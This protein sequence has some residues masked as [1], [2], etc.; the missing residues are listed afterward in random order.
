LLYCFLW[1]CFY[2]YLFG[3]WLYRWANVLSQEARSFF[4]RIS[5]GHAKNWYFEVGQAFD[6]LPNG[7]LVP[8]T[9]THIRTTCIQQMLSSRPWASSAEARIFLEGWDK[10][11]MWAS[12]K[13]SLDSCSLQSDT[14][15][16]CCDYNPFL[17]EDSPVES[18]SLK[19]WQRYLFLFQVLAERNIGHVIHWPALQISFRSGLSESLVYKTFACRGLMY[20]LV[21]RARPASLRC[22][23]VEHNIRILVG[24]LNKPRA[25][26]KFPAK[27]QCNGRQDSASHSQSRRY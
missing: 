4:G 6:A 3:T 18:V 7:H 27:N 10:G 25:L 14:S 22:V 5:E 23:S 26:A 16:S 19:N 12:Q 17:S 13:G 15:S 21:W 20:G 11:E 8:C 24:H 9:R 2:P 1:L